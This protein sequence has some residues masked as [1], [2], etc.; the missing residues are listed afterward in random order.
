MLAALGAVFRDDAGQVLPA[1]GGG[2]QRIHSV[3]TSGLPDLSATEIIIAGD[4][5][6][7][8]TGADG[9]A[10]VYGPQR[11]ADAGQVRVL[12]AGLTHLVTY[13]VAAGYTDAER[14]AATPGA[15][16][17]GG[18]GFGAMLLGGRAVSGADYFLSLL[19]FDEHLDGGDTARDP[20]L[21]ARVL[22]QLGWTIPLPGHRAT[23]A[24][25]AA[26]TPSTATS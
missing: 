19:S 16:A 9:A 3:D 21:T 1:N 14:L 7:P 24:P 13:L 2:L 23:P 11:G 10:A 5:Q 20:D 12:D 6:N 22:E 17:A 18:L 8:L 25:P 26:V 4:V 15:G